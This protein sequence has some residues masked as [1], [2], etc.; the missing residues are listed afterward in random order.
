MYAIRNISVPKFRSQCNTKSNF[1]TMKSRCFKNFNSEN[2]HKDL[3]LPWYLVALEDNPEIACV[4]WQS[5]FLSVIDNQAPHKQ[6]R[7]RNVTSPLDYSRLKKA[8][9]S[10]T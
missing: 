3:M 10:K 2:F 8:N 1:K 9:V 4:K 6:K 7:V 5:M